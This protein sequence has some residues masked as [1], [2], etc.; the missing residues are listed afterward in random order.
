[1]CNKYMRFGLFPGQGYFIIRVVYFQCATLVKAFSN[2]ADN[3]AIGAEHLGSMNK[4]SKVKV[5][6]G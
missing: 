4:R 5:C 3:S 6:Y 2:K 1:M